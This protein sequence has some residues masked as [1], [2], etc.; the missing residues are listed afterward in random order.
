MSDTPMLKRILVLLGETSASAS[1]RQY[2][3]R[4]AQ[5]TESDMAGLAGIDLTYIEAP[6][7]GGIGTSAYKFRLEEQLKKQA[8]DVRR[9]LH[10]KF[11]L[12]CRNHNLP[13][14]WLSFEG[15]PIE[16]LYLATETRDLVITGHDTAFCGNVHEQLSELLA[17]LLLITP[18]PVI[19]CPDDLSADDEIL[20]AYD[21]SVPA[22]RA[23]QIFTLLGIG[24]GKRIHVTSVDASQ[25]LA[26]RRTA[27]AASYLRN[28]GY[29][30]DTSPIASRVHPAEVLNIE[31]ADRKIGTLVMGAYGHRGFREVLFGSTTSA[32]V[33]SPPC[34]LFVYH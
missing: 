24:Q 13:F 34:A 25:E 17:K 31:I 18:R 29:E 22:M 28:H 26:A 14:E 30:V 4:L 7:P 23:V 21:G 2:A 11:E 20:I 19:I 9:R 10:D 33:E 27:G 15:D 12:E 6:M 32:L 3:F 8:T 16:T 5:R 1:A